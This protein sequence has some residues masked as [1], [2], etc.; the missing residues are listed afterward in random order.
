M[1]A[2]ASQDLARQGIRK[3]LL[4]RDRDWSTPRSPS[5]TRRHEQAANERRRRGSRT[6]NPRWRALGATC[7]RGRRP[8][9]VAGLGRRAH[10]LPGLRAACATSPL[11]GR[12]K[13]N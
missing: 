13:E 6:P 7:R 2:Y 8:A 11:T 10:R 4:G 12:V 5:V 3:G 9:D 1:H